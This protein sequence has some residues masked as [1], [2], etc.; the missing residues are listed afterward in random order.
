MPL[1]CFIWT[2]FRLVVG[3]VLVDLWNASRLSQLVMLTF[4]LIADIQH[5]PISDGFSF[6]G[7]PRYYRHALQTAEIAAVKFQESNVDFALNL[8]D[9]IDGKCEGGQTANSALSASY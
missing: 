4:G 7:V 1:K 6:G 2:S 3:N 5:A 8:G 9:T